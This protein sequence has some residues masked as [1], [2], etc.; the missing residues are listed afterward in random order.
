MERRGRLENPSCDLT[1]VPTGPPIRHEKNGLSADTPR[2][3]AVNDALDRLV[4]GGASRLRR[5]QSVT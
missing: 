1:A 2:P 4:E 3:V 5:A